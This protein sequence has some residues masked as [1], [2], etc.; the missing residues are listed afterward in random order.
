MQGSFPR[1]L[2]SLTIDLFGVL[3]DPEVLE[4]CSQDALHEGSL[5]Q[6]YLTPE[7]L[8]CVAI[9]KTGDTFIYQLE[10]DGKLKPT[11]K[12]MMALA[13]ILI[14]PPAKYRPVLMIPSGRG[15]ISAFGASDIGIPVLK[16]SVWI[17]AHGLLGFFA[18][19]HTDGSLAVLDMRGPTFILRDT[20]PS[21]PRHSFL[22]QS[23]VDQFVSLSL[24]VFR[25][26]SG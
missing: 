2:P 25:L 12:D 5:A 10:P 15:P 3:S 22:K 9:F 13:H 21:S 1:P 19:A 7:S 4:R 17:A 11:D 24:A 14:P 18:F 26:S 6:V 16:V 20:N 8:E 23:T